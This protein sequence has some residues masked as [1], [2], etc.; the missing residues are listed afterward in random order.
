MKFA[1]LILGTGLIV[2]LGIGTFTFTYNK[3]SK[4]EDAKSQKEDSVDIS[5][6][7]EKNKNNVNPKEVNVI[8]NESEVELEDNTEI[9][10][11]S[12]TDG[13]L[14]NNTDEKTLENQDKKELS[15]VNNSI[16]NVE[17][18]EDSMENALNIIKSAQDTKNIETKEISDNFIF[19]G[20]S[21]T[22]AYKDIV[23]IS[24]YDFITF[25][26]KESKGYE[27]FATEGLKKLENRL[28]TTDLKYNIVLNLGVN[29][30]N[31][32]SKYSSLYNQLS[33]KYPQ[34]N[35]FVV[36]VNPGDEAKMKSNGYNYTTNA[37]IEDF[38]NNLK[39]SLN[40]NITYIDTYSK[41]IKEGF[42]TTDGLHYSQNTS[43]Y[44]LDFVS[45]FIK[46]K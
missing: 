16:I 5:R 11:E 4:I 34:H 17:N 22:V 46:S 18:S 2:A 15:S 23:D 26:A 6:L 29:D 19:I 3:F 12:S 43:K 14:E 30:L 31:N 21:R 24:N 44:I 7:I 27:W 32:I 36:S 45:N 39:N 25:I 42:N 13:I 9:E 20:D 33:N 10:E 38:N 40:E 41:L 37:K 1:K 28:H 8:A 35:F